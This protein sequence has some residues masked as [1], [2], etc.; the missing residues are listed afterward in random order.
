L[1]SASAVFAQGGA[2]CLFSDPDGN[3]CS[4]NDPGPGLVTVYVVH[5]QTAGASASRF[6]A[7]QPSCAT[8]WTYIA[9]TSP[10]PVV[11]GN[12]QTGVAVAYGG[13]LTG[14]IHVL[15]IN[16]FT[17]G[18]VVDCPYEVLPEP[19][20]GHIE[21]VDCAENLL[22]AEGGTTFINSSLPCVCGSNPNPLLHVSPLVLDFGATDVTQSFLIAN[23]GGGTLT[24]DVT[25]TV[26]W[27]DASPTSGTNGET[28]VVT[29]DRTGLATGYHSGLI[30][31]T[32]NAGNETVTV[33]MTVVDPDPV[34][35]V[36]PP[37]LVFSTT[38]MEQVL[39]IFNA[40]SGHLDWYILTDQ[41]WIT[42]H[43]P[44]G[45]NDL[46]VTIRVDRTGLPGGTYN[47]NLFVMSNGGDVTVPVF[48][49]VADPVPVLHVNPSALSFGATLTE[50]ILH[51]V[52]IGTG[53]LD[54]NIASDQT[55]L[56]ANPASGTNDTDVTVGV[57][58]TGL[59]D[60]AHQGNLTVTSNGGDAVVPVDIWVG[61][62][63]VL[64]VDPTTLILTPSDTS[65]TF[66]I[67]NVGD[68]TL[69]WELDWNAP[70][71]GIVPPHWG[72]GDATVTVF[73]DPAA[74]PPGGTQVGHINVSSNGG[75]ASVEVRY[76]PPGLQWGGQIG[77]YSDVIG[78]DCNIVDQGGLL[79]VHVVHTN[80]SGAT[81]A[82][83]AAPAPS[84]MT[85]VTWLTDNLVFP[86]ALGNSQTG[87]TVAYG[88]CLSP[89]I[90]VL[91]ILYSTFATSETC[92]MYPV[93]P[94]PSVASGK[95]EVVDCTSYKL[96][97]DGRIS[98]VNPNSHCVCGTV[99]VHQATWG[100][101]KAL[102]GPDS[103]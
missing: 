51:V 81:A 50:R 15:T 82:Q 44:I 41:T 102:Y 89:S 36:S 64:S 47:G 87:I 78:S 34:L 9:D 79:A 3:E 49:S 39:N 27:L 42:A 96:F 33:N 1:L 19:G 12:S 35:G 58:R 40:G 100:K 43:P 92:C 8:G 63:P 53:D 31:I 21:V 38:D 72:S 16:Y 84:C 71:I 77:V 69:D 80:T 75:A 7:P 98:I 56:S 24:W 48:M 97:A 45:D 18:T 73:V 67:A 85:G 61:P 74:V 99:V 26:P 2:L 88:T 10:F 83:F 29:V 90:H 86:I 68:G 46:D 20:V 14:P 4:I 5:T 30:N 6:S 57:D 17:A 60:G 103:D 91:T 11:I 59:A 65:G 70:W 95:I 101:I 28:I 94:D 37:A 52:N 76:V 93:I 32:S 62:Q 22:V 13:C 23:A 66:S 55:W 54:W 25:E